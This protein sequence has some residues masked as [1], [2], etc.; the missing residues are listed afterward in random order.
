MGIG[1]QLLGHGS[2]LSSSVDVLTYDNIDCRYVKS[3]PQ[4]APPPVTL[5][6]RFVAAIVLREVQDISRRPA[7]RP[8]R[9]EVDRLLAA[10]RQR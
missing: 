3:D 10:T 7:R 6:G 9:E 1:A 8:E 5:L 4:R 2:S